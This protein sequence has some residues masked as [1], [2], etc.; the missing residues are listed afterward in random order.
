LRVL[1]PPVQKVMPDAGHVA[2]PGLLSSPRV[3]GRHHR[4]PRAWASSPPC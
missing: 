1:V 3:A 2:H 4:G